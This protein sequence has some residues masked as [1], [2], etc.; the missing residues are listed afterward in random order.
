MAAKKI[1]F[2]DDVR[3][4]IRLGVEKLA[5][6]VKCTLGPSGRNVVIHKSWGSPQ[7]TKDG[8]T[9]AEQIEFRDPFQN[10]GARL[11]REVASKTG[12][13]A[14]DGTTT[15]TVLAEAI[16]VQGLKAVT[17]G[18]NPID[19]KNGIDAAVAAVVADLDKQ[20][21]KVKGDFAKIAQVGAISA[22]NDEAIGKMIADAMQKVGEDGV[23]TV[24]EGKGIKDE[25]DVVEGMQFDRG[26]VSPNFITDP[27]NLIA[28]LENPYILIHEK[29]ISSVQDLVP[30]LE[31]VAKANR[32]LLVI[33]EDV[34]GEAL[35]T[36]VVNNMRKV[37]KCC[38][39]KA[40]GY[41][42]R[43]KA[44]LQDIAILTGG[45]ALF[46]DL[47]I[48]LKN[49]ELSDLGQAKAV[50]VEKEYTTIIEGAGKRSDVQARIKQIRKE[51]EET[52]S[53]YDREKLQERLAKLAGGVAVIRPGAATEAEMKERKDRIDDA[54]HA[55]RAAVE[56]GI[57]AGGGTAYIRAIPAVQALK[58][59]GDA[60]I[61]ADIVAA[62]LRLPTVTIAAN[63]GQEGEVIANRVAKESGTIGYNAKT[64]QF[65]DLVKSG[66]IDPV[67]VAKS[68]LV[69]AASVA[70]LLLNTEAMIAEIKEPKKE[71]KKGGHGHD[72]G[73]E[74]MEGG[75]DF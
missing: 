15:A 26:Y 34:E 20:A 52:K 37:L 27:D 13:Q 55:T 3:E 17:S 59:S 69:N 54:L 68:A 44:M 65:E 70:T 74:E 45:K 35:A 28:E 38:A 75:D 21:I 63:A 9:V 12:Q 2:N 39:V 24:E 42:D 11:V 49:V 18:V 5:R 14:G 32:S 56:E 16:F 60:R 40:P 50:K 33:A 53:D 58:L 4:N 73:D 57:V 10:M 64:G 47:G 41:G 23:I 51:I 36:L 62:A 61:G 1:A 31:K 48:D 25:V 66:V 46:E 6:A 30:L 67:K 7:V 43:R 71:S 19:L 72:H 22:N 29:K 8:V